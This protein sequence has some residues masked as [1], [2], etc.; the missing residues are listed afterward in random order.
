METL[1]GMHALGLHPVVEELTRGARRAR[2]RRANGGIAKPDGVEPRPGFGGAVVQVV[3]VRHR[4]VAPVTRR[5]DVADLVVERKG[6]H[7][8]VRLDEAPMLLGLQPRQ[9]RLQRREEACVQPGAQPAQMSRLRGLEDQQVD[10]LLRPGGAD[11]GGGANDDVARPGLVLL[12]VAAVGV[13]VADDARRRVSEHA[14]SPSSGRRYDPLAGLAIS[15]ISVAQVP[16]SY[17]ETSRGPMSA[18]HP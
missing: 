1:G 9:D 4:R 13:I 5:V 14:R 18:L 10:D 2:H 16:M 3:Q 6:I 17:A 12:P 7:R 11:L 8:Q 15:C